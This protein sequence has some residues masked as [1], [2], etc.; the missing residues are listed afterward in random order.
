MRSLREDTPRAAFYLFVVVSGLWLVW[1]GHL[2]FSHPLLGIV[3]LVSAS[4]VVWLCW[5]MDLVDDETVPLHLTPGTLR[6]VP[7]L[8]W[9]VILSSLDVL[10]RCITLDVEPEVLT[11]EG[12][13]RTD[14]GLVSYANSI[15]LTPGTTSIDSDAVQH[16]ITVHAISKT[17]ADSLRGGEMDRRVA[18]VEGAREYEDAPRSEAPG[19][20]L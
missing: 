16:L 12:S 10:R 18:A 17:T 3:G 4:L 13:Q 11:V 8:A 7:W 1:S 2:S 15:T 6:Y 9:Q 5:K 20:E 14:V 19:S